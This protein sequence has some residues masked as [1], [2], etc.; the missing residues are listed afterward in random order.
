MTSSTTS[1]RPQVAQ[2]VANR[3]PIETLRLDSRRGEAASPWNAASRW[4]T[5]GGRR[6]TSASIRVSGLDSSETARRWRSTAARATQPPRPNRSAT[7]SP[8][9]VWSSI[10]AATS[11]G[12][13]AGASRSK[14]GSE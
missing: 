14:T 10:R 5:S 7:T 1:I 13:G 8:G 3:S 9:P 4:R 6:T 2:R 11:A 12:G